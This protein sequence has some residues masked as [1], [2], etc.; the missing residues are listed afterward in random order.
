MLTRWI[1]IVFPTALF[2]IVE[3]WGNSSSP[4]FYTVGELFVFANCL[5]FTLFVPSH[6][7]DAF[8][9]SLCF[10]QQ[11]SL[12]LLLIKPVI[13]SVMMPVSHTII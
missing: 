8:V 13:Y 6:M 11:I 12:K 2:Y 4:A 1:A 7:S 9:L 3:L 5:N 10:S